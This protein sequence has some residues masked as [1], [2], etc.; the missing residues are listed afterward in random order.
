MVDFSF[1]KWTSGKGLGEEGGDFGF[2]F[3]RRNCVRL[4]V[5][6]FN[7]EDNNNREDGG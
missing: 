2:R 1:E 7:N 6:Y 3:L 5:E 4:R